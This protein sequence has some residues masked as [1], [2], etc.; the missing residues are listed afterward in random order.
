MSHSLLHG[1]KM[2]IRYFFEQFSIREIKNFEKSYKIML[3]IKPR[4]HY[5]PFA[6]ARCKRK[7]FTNIFLSHF[8]ELYSGLLLSSDLWSPKMQI[9]CQSLSTVYL[10]FFSFSRSLFFY[11]YLQIIIKY[12]WK[13]ILL[14]LNIFSFIKYWSYMIELKECSLCFI[15]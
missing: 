1:C 8:L 13:L 6:L 4:S 15:M 9:Q 12:Y 3:F 11:W 5:F 2:D 7:L 10:I 14:F